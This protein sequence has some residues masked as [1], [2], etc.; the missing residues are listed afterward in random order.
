MGTSTYS[1]SLHLHDKPWS[2]IISCHWEVQ[3]IYCLVTRNYKSLLELIVRPS[4]PDSTIM[5]PLLSV[6]DEVI[7]LLP[8]VHDAGWR[9]RTRTL[10]E[11]SWHPEA[12]VTLPTTHTDCGMMPVHRV[13][14]SAAWDC[15]GIS[16]ETPV[17]WEHPQ[18]W[19]TR[20][21]HKELDMTEQIS[22]EGLYQMRTSV[23][24]L[25][26]CI[27]VLFCLGS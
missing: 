18:S 24:V 3:S 14:N 17:S 23:F 9:G 19:Q 11:D 12:H 7:R 6:W 13:T 20:M 27:L 2:Q 15:P 10:R 5:S 4:S 16:T 8:E 21:V 1:T 26:P 22:L 25:A